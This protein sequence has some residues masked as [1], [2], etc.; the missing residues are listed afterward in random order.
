MT[1]SVNV[2]MRP[3]QTRRRSRVKVRRGSR[4]VNSN[5]IGL[6]VGLSTTRAE[7]RNGPL[8]LIFARRTRN[9]VLDLA[10]GL[11]AREVNRTAN[12]NALALAHEA[13]HAEPEQDEGQ[14]DQ[15]PERQTF[16][17]LLKALAAPSTASP[18]DC[19]SGLPELDG[20]FFSLGGR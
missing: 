18:G 10:P 11:S 5:S 7:K 20:L 2:I 6:G 1:V 14:H 15:G 16:P 8:D 17:S 13:D 12:S 19:H 9:S 4:S 3:R